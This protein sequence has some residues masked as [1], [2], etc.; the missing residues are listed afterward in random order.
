MNAVIVL[1]GRD[2]T[3]HILNGPVQMQIDSTL[4]NLADFDVKLAPLDDTESVPLQCIT[5]IQVCVS[6]RSV[7]LGAPHPIGPR[8]LQ[9]IWVY[10]RTPH[11]GAVKGVLGMAQN[12]L[13]LTA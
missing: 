5:S 8:I 9:L 11:P 1:N 12:R 7:C 2:S 13:F 10:F 4:N 3:S 6:C